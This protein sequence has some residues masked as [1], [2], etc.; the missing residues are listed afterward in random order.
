MTLSLHAAIDIA[1]TAD[2]LSLEKKFHLHHH[3]K[4]S[5]QPSSNTCQS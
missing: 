3:I 1:A 4:N 5:S 2:V